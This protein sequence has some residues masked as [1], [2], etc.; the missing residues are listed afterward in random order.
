MNMERDVKYRTRVGCLYTGIK[1]DIH[2]YNLLFGGY[3]VR[4]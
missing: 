4:L 3:G 1:D 2:S